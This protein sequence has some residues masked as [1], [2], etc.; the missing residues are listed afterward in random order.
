MFQQGYRNLP[1]M[2]KL[3]VVARCEGWGVVAR[4]GGDLNN[5]NN[6]E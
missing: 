5:N 2:N 6:N 1:L 3:Q 4:C